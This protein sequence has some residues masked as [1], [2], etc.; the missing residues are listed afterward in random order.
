MAH[1]IQL[2]NFLS[3]AETEFDDHLCCGSIVIIYCYAM[4]SVFVFVF[5]NFYIDICIFI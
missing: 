1:F 5:G 3:S 4:Y 2:R